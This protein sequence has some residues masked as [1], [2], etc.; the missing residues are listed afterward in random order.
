Q[1]RQIEAVGP[2]LR[3]EHPLG[4]R[5]LVWTARD[6]VH[7]LGWEDQERAV[8]QR[9]GSSSQDLRGD[10]RLRRIDLEDVAHRARARPRTTRSRPAKSSNTSTWSR[11]ASNNACTRAPW[12]APISTTS[13]PPGTSHAGASSTSR[14]WTCVPPTRASYGS[15]LTSSGRVSYSSRVTYGGLLTRRS[16]RPRR[17]AG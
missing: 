2:P 11:R 12:S 15:A 13:H 14:S 4:R 6:P 17:S 9:P 5:R 3:S 10:I 16:S 8:R 7:G 1:H